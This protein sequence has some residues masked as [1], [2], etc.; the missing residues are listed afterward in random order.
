MPPEDNGLA[1]R[2]MLELHGYLDGD[3]SQSTPWRERAEAALRAAGTDERLGPEGKV[4]A[5]WLLALEL[6]HS[7][8]VDVTVVGEVGDPTAEALWRAALA[9]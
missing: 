6:L 5:R 3:G 4:I 9:L 7:T 2:F 8:S 1:A